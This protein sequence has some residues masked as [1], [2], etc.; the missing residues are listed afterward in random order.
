V[1]AP[2]QKFGNKRIKAAIETKD[3]VKT[4]PSSN[5]VKT[6]LSKDKKEKANEKRRLIKQGDSSS[7][8]MFN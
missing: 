7:S 1:G 6:V 4:I 8:S 5:A 2:G 3:T